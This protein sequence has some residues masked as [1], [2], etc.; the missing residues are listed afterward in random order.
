MEMP[1]QVSDWNSI[2][3]AAT[4]ASGPD[5]RGVIGC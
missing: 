2:K 1:G 3:Q 5:G 4:D